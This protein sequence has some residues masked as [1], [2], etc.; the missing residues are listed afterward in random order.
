MIEAMTIGERIT[1]ARKAVGLTQEE[2]GRRLG[3][4]ASM[5]SQYETGARTPKVD[6]IKRFSAALNAPIL[7]VLTDERRAAVARALL[8]LAT[9]VQPDACDGC[10]HDRSCAI[11]GCNIILTAV[12]LLGGKVSN[13]D[14]SPQ[15]T[16]LLEQ[17]TMEENYE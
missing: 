17:S 10:G 4:S 1:K 6:T 7:D 12:E 3:V 8:P 5:V 15:A 13:L 11:R 2:L 14:A 9:R 16:D